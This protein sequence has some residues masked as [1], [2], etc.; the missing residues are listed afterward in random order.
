LRIGKKEQSEERTINKEGEI[1][2]NVSWLACPSVREYAYRPSFSMPTFL[3]P[4]AAL[5]NKAIW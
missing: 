1:G 4:S 2:R 5:S 3:V